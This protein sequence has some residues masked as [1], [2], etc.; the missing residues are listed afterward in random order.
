MTATWSVSD[1][2][3]ERCVECLLVQAPRWLHHEVGAERLRNA[4][5]RQ[6][7]EDLE[8]VANVDFA[9]GF[10]R[11][12]PHERA[13]LEDY[14]FKLLPIG[15]KQ[16]LVTS[17]RFYGGDVTRPF[18]QLDHT[19]ISIVDR[20]GWQIVERALRDAY[21]H[22]ALPRMRVFGASDEPLRDLSQRAVHCDLRYLAATLGQ[23][24]RVELPE[25]GADLR[26]ER[27]TALSDDSFERY[28]EI[29][30]GMRSRSAIHR[31]MQ[32]WHQGRADFD[33]ALA[34]GL[35]VEVL[36]DGAWAGLFAYTPGSDLCFD[37]F[38]VLEAALA[39]RVRG[40]GIAAHVHR[41]MVEMLA[42]PDDAVLFGTVVEGN[43]PSARAAMRSGRRVSGAYWFVDLDG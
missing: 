41:R 4:A 36:V 30:R 12:C 9:R 22:L 28:R 31:P 11:A 16:W 1:E 29:Y 21:G 26:L 20:N 25:C 2:L 19:T 5:E 24:R 23:L 33:K 6:V 39:E 7:R 40:R 15:V 35:V 14:A 34:G 42:A 18:V 17:L 8:R 37:G 43:D 10:Q 32:V 13:E 38:C 3:V 27:V